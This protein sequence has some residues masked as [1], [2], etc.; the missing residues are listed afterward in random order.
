MARVAR[1]KVFAAVVVVAELAEARCARR[2]QDHPARPGR[3]GQAWPTG[4]PPV[5]RRHGGLQ[6]R[7][8][9]D[10]REGDG[11]DQRTGTGNGTGTGRSVRLRQSG[12]LGAVRLRRR[13][14]TS[15]NPLPRDVA[16]AG[17]RGAQIAFIGPVNTDAG[18]RCHT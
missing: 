12:S 7:A 18:H 1:A 5:S 6:V 17:L 11:P 3:A 8:V 10:A 4:I 15:G 16:C 14:H 9:G 13:G 2:Q